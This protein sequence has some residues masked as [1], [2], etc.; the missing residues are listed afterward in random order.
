HEDIERQLEQNPSLIKDQTFLNN[1]P[2]LQAFLKDHAQ[3]QEEFTENPQFFILRLNRYE[4]SPADQRADN[5]ANRA[6]N[7]N[8][9]PDLTRREVASMD[10]FL[11]S[12]E[13]IERQ[14]EQNPSLIKDQTFLNNHPQLQAFLKDHA[15][16]Q[17][18]FTENPQFFILRLNRYE[19]SPA[20]Q[21]ADNNAN[22]AN[23]RNP[24]PDLTRR[25]V[26]SMDQ[27]LDSHEDI[28]RQL[29]Q[30]PS[31]IN[32]QAFLNNHAQ[33]QDF[34]KDHPEVRE[35]FAE[36]PQFFI[37]RLNRYESS[38]A[39]QRADNNANRANNRNPNPDLTRREVASMD[40]FLDSHEDIERQLE[41]NPS[42]IN[43]QAFLN[44]HAQLQDFLKDHPEVREEFAENPQFFIVRMN[45][46]EGSPADQRADNRTNTANANSGTGNTNTATERNGNPD[47][48]RGEVASMD[49]F[50][51]SHD[52]IEAQLRANPS[53][54][55]NVD[56]LSKHQD[57][58]AFLSSHPEVREEFTENPSLFM[59]REA[60]YESTEYRGGARYV[61]R[62]RDMNQRDV[63]TMDAYL[64]RHADEARDLEA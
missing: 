54:I 26:A 12:H 32:N 63:A 22:R 1:H 55:N 14:L 13:N 48:T 30:N 36:N 15:Q 20:D 33:L 24:N 60:Q 58:R 10:Q 21:R 52:K 28:E 16:I 18:E 7:R 5:N 35:E 50:L 49:Q 11:D 2:Q 38:P 47:L 6:N 40:Q 37:L 27:F 9:N 56:Y 42:L 57:L 19:S 34:L 4:S 51:D 44:N 45:R 46:F 17:E 3:I 62:D 23:N 59:N 39:D 43:D 31:L 41:Q 25:E 64:D 61:D 8:P 53:L 29:E